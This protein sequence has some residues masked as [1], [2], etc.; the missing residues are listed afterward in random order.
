MGALIHPFVRI[1]LL[2][3]KPQ[4]LPASGTL[5]ALV[6]VAHTVAGVAVAAVNLRFDQA[7]AAGV[8]DT[9]LM[10]ALTTG[11]LMLRTLRERTVQTLTALAGAGTVIGVAAY[12]VSVWLHGAQEANAPAPALAVLLIAVL[13]WSLTVSAH[14]LRHAISAPFYIGLLLS[15]AFYWVSIRVL[16]N[17]FPIGA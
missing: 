17:L 10:C 14:I 6:L 2:R 7:L 3:M 5:L 1:C 4:D 11:L 9:A 13:G 8:V 16:S 12:P 15:I